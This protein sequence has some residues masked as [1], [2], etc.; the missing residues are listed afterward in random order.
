MLG[1]RE[2]QARDAIVPSRRLVEV[3]RVL[4]QAAKLHGSPPPMSDAGHA[5]ALEPRDQPDWVVGVRCITTRQAAALLGLSD[6][7]V[8]R[9][10]PLGI[11]SRVGSMLLFDETEV[12][13]LAA[14]RARSA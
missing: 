13:T 1:L 5:L 2:V 6:R 4:R 12:V 8:R 10:W 14:C 3:T 9:L 11:A 7:Q